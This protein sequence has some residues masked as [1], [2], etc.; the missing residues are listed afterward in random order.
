MPSVQWPNLHRFDPVAVRRRMATGIGE[1]EGMTSTTAATHS[2]RWNRASLAALV[3]G[4]LAISLTG[5]APPASDDGVRVLPAAEDLSDP[6]AAEPPATQPD[7]LMVRQTVRQALPAA[8][9]ATHQATSA[10]YRVR[11]HDTLSGI[12]R[13]ELGD[14]TRYQEIFALNRGRV[15][16]DGG[17]LIDPDDIRPGWELRLPAAHAAAVVESS[18]PV[19]HRKSGEG[20]A[21]H[22]TTR[23]AT[24][25]HGT[26][27]GESARSIAAAVVPSG[28]L[29]CFS[30]IISHESGWNVHA[31]NPS[32]GAYGLPQALPG[33]KMASSGSDWRDDADTQI[34][35]ALRYMDSRYGSPCSAWSFWEDHHWY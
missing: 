26:T 17:K 15:Q 1:A 33:S 23:P 22:P 32:S 35:W 25:S 3:T 7:L 16:A 24:A 27:T 8:V 29:S 13:T 12:A 11:P 5:A 14:A 9:P 18:T 4:S 21:P 6:P 30:E 31:V 28:Q 34:R 2:N 10:V 20:K 19:Q